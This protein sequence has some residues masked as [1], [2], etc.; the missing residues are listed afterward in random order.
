MANFCY[1]T[2]GNNGCRAM[3]Y[4]ALSI[5]CTLVL[6]TILAKMSMIEMTRLIFKLD[7]IEAISVILIFNN[8]TLLE[9]CVRWR[10]RA[11]ACS[12]LWL[13]FAL[14]VFLG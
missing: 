13:V 9:W 1:C 10:I 12:R 6:W 5:P 3:R 14:E 11:V 8:R 4:Y 7:I 2:S